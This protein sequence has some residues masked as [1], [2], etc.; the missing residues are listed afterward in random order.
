MFY[1][2]V[3]KMPDFDVFS[4]LEIRK[5][6]RNYLHRGYKSQVNIGKQY[7]CAIMQADLCLC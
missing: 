3:S 5:R 4:L 1:S 6:K 2:A 7:D